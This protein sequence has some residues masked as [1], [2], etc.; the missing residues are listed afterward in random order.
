MKT[1]LLGGVAAL[2]LAIVGA[3]L[4]ATYVQAADTRAQAGLSPVEVLIV[5]QPITA[6]TAVDQL[7]SLVKAESIPRTAVAEGAVTDLS[8]FS[9]KVAAVALVPGEQLLANRLVNPDSLLAPNQVDVPKG[10]EEVTL[11]LAPERVLGGQLRA[12][13]TVGL[14]ISYNDGVAPG[15][16]DVQATKLQFHKVLVTRVGTGTTAPSDGATAQGPP[17]GS[18]EGI[19][20]TLAQSGADAVRTVHG[21]E[22][23]KIYLSR[24]NADS[25]PAPVNTLHKDGVLK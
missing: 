13:D 1:R 5:Q 8:S 10:L 24:E 22:F 20:I 11:K 12:G 3:V 15:T 2:V 6:G 4:L 9:G 18:G 17:A 25:N 23:G 16:R 14:F 19:F 7:K 21:I